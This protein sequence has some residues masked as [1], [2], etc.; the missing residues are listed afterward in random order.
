MQ[1]HSILLVEDEEPVAKGVRY[2]LESEGWRVTW[3]PDARAAL[4]RVAAA[5]PDLAVLD[6]RLPGMS[7][8]DLCREIRRS[9]TFPVLFLTARDEELDRV[10][11]LELGADDY[12][13][14]PFAVRELVARIRALLRRSYGEYAAPGVSTTITRGDLVID[15]ERR[16]VTRAGRPVDLTTTEFD[17]LREMA[18]QPGRVFSREALLRAVRDDTGWLG[19]ETTITVHIRHLREKLEARPD[20]PRHILTVRGVG[21]TFAEE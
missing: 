13:S 12:L 16:R 7:G 6:V 10:L 3:A 8:F 17:I 4:D 2:A 19:D 9:H 11:G 21:Y 15:V 18:R 14:K 5:P 20:E 1:Q